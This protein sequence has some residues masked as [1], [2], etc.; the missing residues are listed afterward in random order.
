MKRNFF[1][2]FFLIFFSIIFTFIIVEI[3]LK[4]NNKNN[5][6]IIPLDLNEPIVNKFDK[7]LGW[8]LQ[9]GVYYYESFG[10]EKKN[11]TI[12]ITENEYRKSADEIKKKKDII[13]LGGS[14]TFGFGVNDNETFV[15]NINK[16]IQNYNFKNY[17]TG[18]Y[19]TYQS[20]LLLERILKNNK[21]IDHIFAIYNK[22][23]EIRNVGNEEWLGILTKFS[24]RGYLKLPYAR[25]DKNG[26]L[27]RKKPI[28]YIELPL[29]DNL[30][31][32]NKIEKNIMRLIFFLNSSNAELT[33]IK[34][35]D[36]MNELS[37]QN[38]VK[39][40]VLSL[41]GELNQNYKNFFKKNDITQ[42]EC[43]LPISEPYVIKGDGHPNELG[44]K[45]IANCILDQFSKVL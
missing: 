34:I 6:K 32:V 38:N 22:D 26:N 44:H 39:L 37:K 21:N 35:F 29:S 9:K 40:T 10:T 42:I 25:L 2:N 16:K 31:T 45:Q 20:Y 7:E 17:G 28:K 8:K 41:S 12:T 1:I 18:G 19:G 3:F 36:K 24:K 5:Q 13:F 23:H 27:I 43:N 33:T 14:I 15:S 11:F 4:I 30:L